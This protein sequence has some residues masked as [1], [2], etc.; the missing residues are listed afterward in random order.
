MI[1]CHTGPLSAAVTWP[2]IGRK[3][4]M[5]TFSIFLTVRAAT[6]RAKECSSEAPPMRRRR[7]DAHRKSGARNARCDA[8]SP[9]RLRIAKAD[10]QL[11]A[12][13]NLTGPHL[14][15]RLARTEQFSCRLPRRFPRGVHQ[16][17]GAI[18]AHARPKERQ[19]AEH[20]FA[21]LGQHHYWG[22]RRTVRVT[23]A[24]LR[25][26]KIAPI[27]FARYGAALCLAAPIRSQ[28]PAPLVHLTKAS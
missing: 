20:Q 11:I 2:T 15:H 10:N 6:G 14:Q 22:K 17:G 19:S 4:I 12:V 8:G 21:N 7:A 25:G 28:R 27:A 24:G 18:A 16:L 26:A 5:Q 3:A 9:V 23:P 13:A 1:G